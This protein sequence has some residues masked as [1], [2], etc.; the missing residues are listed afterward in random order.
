M[1]RMACW[2]QQELRKSLY[3]LEFLVIGPESAAASI[4]V[5]AA[6]GFA[7]A[8]CLNSSLWRYSRRSCGVMES[9]VPVRAWAVPPPPPW[10]PLPPPGPPEPPPV[11]ALSCSSALA[12]SAFDAASS[13][14]TADFRTLRWADVHSLR[15]RSP[16]C[17]RHGV[18]LMLLPS[19]RPRVFSL[20]ALP[21]RSLP[22]AGA[23]R[24]QRRK[25]SPPCFPRLDSRA[26]LTAARVKGRWGG[27]P[28]AA[29]PSGARWSGRG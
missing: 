28:A 5:L 20:L 3:P 27:L 11:L 2:F 26:S 12:S 15:K 7:R 13:P 21:A 10:P 14:A 24:R 19:C 29:I 16:S 6:S 18:E 9:R 4:A 22:V 8:H 17:P 1:S 25:N 23:A